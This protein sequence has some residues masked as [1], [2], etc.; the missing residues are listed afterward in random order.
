MVVAANEGTLRSG[1]PSLIY[2]GE[3]VA[4]PDPG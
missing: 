4:L 3:I 1:N 2:P